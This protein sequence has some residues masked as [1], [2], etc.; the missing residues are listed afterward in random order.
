MSQD[1]SQDISQD[2]DKNMVQNQELHQE[3]STLQAKVLDRIGKG[4]S[5]IPISKD[6]S[7]LEKV[8]VHLTRCL[9]ELEHEHGIGSKQ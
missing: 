4:L 9:V 1:V 8:A 5:P 3:I 2:G 7:P 6:S